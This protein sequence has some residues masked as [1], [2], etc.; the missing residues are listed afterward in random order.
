MPGL[1]NGIRALNIASFVLFLF[2][3]YYMCVSSEHSPGALTVVEV[4]D[5]D[6]SGDVTVENDEKE[7]KYDPL[8]VF[9]PTK[10]WKTVK[11]DQAIPAGLHV[12][13]NLET[14]KKEA[15]L[16]D[17]DDGH[18]YW[19]LGDKQGMVNTDSKEFT[20][21]ELKKAL[22]EFK[23]SKHDVP[24]EKRANEIKEKFRSLDQLKD[25]FKKMNIGIKTGQEIV[26]ELYEKLNS[27]DIS[28]NKREAVLEDLEYHLH[29]YDNAVLFCDLGGMPL[30]VKGLNDTDSSLRSLS[31][32]AL[33]SAVQ[34]N[35]KVQIY[36]IESGALHQLIRSL[37][38]DSSLEVKKK[39]LFALSSMIRDFPYAQKKFFELGGLQ[40]MMELF[41][42]DKLRSLQIKVVTLMSDLNDEQNH[43]LSHLDSTEEK[44]IQYQQVPLKDS[45]IHQGICDVLVSL[46]DGVPDHDSREKILFAML[47]LYNTCEP[48]LH[49]TLSNLQKLENEYLNLAVK[50]DDGEYF[51]QIQKNINSLIQ[52]LSLKYE[53]EE[54]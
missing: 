2:C 21:E 5:E 46:L 45:I 50:D 24:N 6:D 28:I 10:E 23:I 12:R 25:D 27:T 11:P 4:D 38:T 19:K 49:K 7:F 15:K 52:Q 48:V 9:Y 40:S 17:G 36:A 43:W 41:R 44:Y 34:S 39:M 13:L 20:H 26:T 8:D 22:K 37:A 3:C 31:A 42:D 54:L 32:Y 53:K 33:G 16:M 35:P 14:G 47:S 18:K 30:L 29:Q 1:V 51:Q